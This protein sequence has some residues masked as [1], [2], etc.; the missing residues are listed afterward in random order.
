MLDRLGLEQPLLHL[1]VSTVVDEFGDAY[2]ELK[3]ARAHI[4]EVV[5]DEENKFE[6]VLRELSLCS[7]CQNLT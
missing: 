3:P 2:P 1:L 5:R 7:S 4:I 6:A